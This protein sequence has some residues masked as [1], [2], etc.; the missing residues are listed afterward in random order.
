MPSR[1]RSGRCRG[2]RFDRLWFF[3][4]RPPTTATEAKLLRQTGSAL[5]V[6][7]RGDWMFTRQ[8]PASAVLVRA[9]SVAACEMPPERLAAPATFETNDIIVMNR[10]PDR[11]SGGPVSLGFGCRFSDS[12]ERLMHGRDQHSELIGPNLVSPNVRG[13]NR[14]REF[15]I[16]RCRLWFVGHF[17][18]PC[19]DRQN[20][21]PGSI[22]VL[23]RLLHI[24][25]LLR[26]P[27]FGSPSKK[28]S[29]L[30]LNRY[31]R[32]EVESE[33]LRRRFTRF[34]RC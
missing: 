15:S 28:T 12:G 13:N 24:T 16:N 17:V 2:F 30:S 7:G 5:R 1:S 3:G 34:Q 10:S 31:H 8:F 33:D 22:E 23:I 4:G 18:S 32:T 26:L 29:G 6:A 27:P 14:R 19:R 21:M 9:Q 25:S 11:H 20:T